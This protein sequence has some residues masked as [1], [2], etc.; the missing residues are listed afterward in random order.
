MNKL[1]PI[2]ILGFVCLITTNCK[3][4]NK[5]KKQETVAQQEKEK[6]EKQE[7]E[8]FDK[9]A[10]EMKALYAQMPFFPAQINQRENFY[11]VRITFDVGTF[12]AEEFRKQGLYGNGYCWAGI[13]EQLIAKKQSKL[14]GKINFDPEADTC[15]IACDDE[16]TMNE[17]ANFIHKELGD[18]KKFNA[19]IQQI[20]KSRL[21]C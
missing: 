17:L 19:I 16:N 15:F 10:E 11:S 20:D 14:L 13:I 3:L 4:N 12:Y 21:D 6:P 2:V 18:K 8:S 5:A 9:M 1:L 7:Q